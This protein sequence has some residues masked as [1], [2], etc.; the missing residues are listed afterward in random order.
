[1]ALERIA[2]YNSCCT[3]TRTEKMAAGE[4][5]VKSNT[6]PVKPERKSRVTSVDLQRA[7]S[8]ENHREE[9]TNLLNRSE[10]VE[11]KSKCIFKTC[12]FIGCDNIKRFSSRGNQF[13]ISTNDSRTLRVPQ[14][15]SVNNYGNRFRKSFWSESAK[16]RRQIRQRGIT[17][18]DAK[19]HTRLRHEKSAFKLK[20]R[21]MFKGNLTVGLRPKG[22]SES[23]GGGGAA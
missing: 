15:F 2:K 12:G 13:S 4:A 14:R 10:P 7:R 22:L 17:A 3:R 18:G 23:C 21:Q 19:L 16:H 5:C 6:T 20:I 1:M 9:A 8:D 11:Q